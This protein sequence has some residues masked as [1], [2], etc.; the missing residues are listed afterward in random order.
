M[1]ECLIICNQSHKVT[2]LLSSHFLYD[3]LSDRN[4]FYNRN[5]N[6]KY[7]FKLFSSK[8]LNFMSKTNNPQVFLRYQDLLKF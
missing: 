5:F 8:D 6:Y 1:S 7:E 2:A 3:F 4:D